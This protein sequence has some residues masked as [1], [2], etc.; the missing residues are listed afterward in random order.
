MADNLAKKIFG[1]Y[2]YKFVDSELPSEYI[3]HI[4]LYIC[5]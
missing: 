3:C 5:S 2:D 4:Y 1:G